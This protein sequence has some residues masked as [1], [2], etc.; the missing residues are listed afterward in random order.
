MII[1]ALTFHKSWMN[2]QICLSW[3]SNFPSFLVVKGV[4]VRVT[5]K[6]LIHDTIKKTAIRR[7]LR[8][9]GQEQINDSSWLVRKKIVYISSG[10]RDLS[11]YLPLPNGP[12]ATHSYILFSTVNLYL[13][14][15]DLVIEKKLTTSKITASALLLIT[16]IR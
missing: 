1:K 9:M 16:C 2:P 14:L 15:D 5:M 3:S 10:I 7:L 8:W 6:G 11:L 13:F 4:C 12:K